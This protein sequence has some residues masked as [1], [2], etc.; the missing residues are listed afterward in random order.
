M[1]R[2]ILLIPR[3]LIWFAHRDRDGSGAIEQPLAGSL[4]ILPGGDE[5]RK[6][7]VEEVLIDLD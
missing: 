5:A 7:V 1:K 2:V 4:V 3:A 6:A